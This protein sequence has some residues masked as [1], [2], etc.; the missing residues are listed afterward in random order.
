MCVSHA[1]CMYVPITHQYTSLHRLPSLSC[2]PC[3]LYHPY[4]T[5]PTIRRIFSFTS[6]GYA[7]VVCSD[8][9]RP[10]VIRPSVDGRMGR[11]ISQHKQC[12]L[13]RRKMTSRAPK[14]R[15]LTFL[16]HRHW[17]IRLFTRDFRIFVIF[18]SKRPSASLEGVKPLVFYQPDLR[19][20]EV[21]IVTKRSFFFRPTS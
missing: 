20:S 8:R 6:T 14:H 17:S 18:F 7:S 4:I 16:S 11:Y 3:F 13:T 21:C 2:P 5:H 15:S 12:F 9:A 1:W 10:A 19:W